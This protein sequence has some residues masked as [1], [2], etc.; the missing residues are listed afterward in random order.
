VV[1]A[2]AFALAR[3]RLWRWLAIT[4]VIAGVLWILPGLE[5]M[6]VVALAPHTFH[7]IAGFALAAA[8][9]VSGFLYGPQAEGRKIDGVSSFALA[10]YLFAATLLVLASRHEALALAAF[11]LLAVATIALAWRAPAATAAIPAAAALVAVILAQWAVY[12]TAGNLIVPGGAVLNIA[13]EPMRTDVGLHLVFGAGFAALFGLAGFFAQARA[14]RPP[15]AILWAACGV[16]A[17]IAILIALYYRI[18]GF[19]RSVSFAAIALLLAA[20]FGWATETLLKRA[21]SPGVAAAGAIHAAATVAALALAI[22]FAL[23]KGWL[24]VGL[25]LMVPGV[26]WIS[27]KRPLP[28]LRWLIVVLVAIVIARIGYEPRIVGQDVGT[29]PIFNWLLYGYGVPA[30]SFWVAGRI[31][32][33][34]ADDIPTR[35]TEAA[36]ILFTVL[37]AFLEIRH[38][39]ND[40]DVYRRSAGLAELALQ[41]SV[42]IAMTI[43][44]EHVRVR[45]RSMIHDLGAIAVAAVTVA[46]LV[47]GLGFSRNPLLTGEPVGGAFVNLILLGYGLP[48]VLAIALALV[49]RTIRPMQYRACAAAISV[50]LALAYL[51]LEVRTLYHGPVLSGGGMS[52]AELYSYSA[53]WL[54]FG[55]ILLIAG[56]YL[57]SQPARLAAAAVI[58]LTIGKV[59]LVDM[60][61]LAGIYRVLSLVGLGLVLMGIGLL[62]QRRLFPA[63]AAD[64]APARDGPV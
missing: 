24:T 7:A 19:E 46:A 28:L 30:L 31:L 15:L 26:A 5:A 6:R 20:L 13:P 35:A 64:A 8:L 60:A 39:M 2:A 55:V 21:P 61:G 25:A 62:Y 54:S 16:L 51:S 59:F 32:R 40:G 44:L 56:F 11:T 58:V 50:I 34:R 1:T 49:T 42:G 41:V 45:S 53:V 18:A 43:G 38:F 9:I 12:P 22:T 23:E 37:L 33:R 3:V 36:A 17:P 52:Q 10:A 63:R 14:N 48:A 29:T 57:R 27:E 4:A 47:F